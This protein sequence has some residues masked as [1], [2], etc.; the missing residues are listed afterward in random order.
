LTRKRKKE[1]VVPPPSPRRR[2]N[3]IEDTIITEKLNVLAMSTR[4]GKY[5]SFLVIAVG[6]LLFL[7]ST[8]FIFSELETPLRALSLLDVRVL[9]AAERR[10][11]SVVI[12]GFVGAVNI[13]CGLLMLAT[14]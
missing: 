13:F 10:I 4:I 14:E 9:F 7:L 6:T 5:V 11:I 12:F 2:G 3:L 8:Q 1:I